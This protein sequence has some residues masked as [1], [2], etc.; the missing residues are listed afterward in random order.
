MVVT[1]SSGGL[2]IAIVSALKAKG[3]RVVCVDIVQ[4]KTKGV[5]DDR[6]LYIQADLTDV[7]QVNT[8]PKTIKSSFN[9][10]SATIVISNA[11]V[12]IGGKVLDFEE[13]QFER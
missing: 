4:S 7:K 13:G 11:G 3:C 5:G 10:A 2:G 9:G 1:G 8:L 12:M 6:T